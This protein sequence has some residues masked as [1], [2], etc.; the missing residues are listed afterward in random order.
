[1]TFSL[2][3]AHR[4]ASCHIEHDLLKSCICHFDQKFSA[5]FKTEVAGCESC[6]SFY[7]RRKCVKTRLYPTSTCPNFLQCDHRPP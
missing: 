5:F 2:T 7:I 3:K 6:D 1:M 4:Y